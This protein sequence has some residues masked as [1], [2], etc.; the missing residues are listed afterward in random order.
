M[1]TVKQVAQLTGLS[2]HTVRFYDDNNLIQG[3]VRNAANQRLFT[4]E[5][6]EWLYM[7]KVMRRAGLTLKEIK[8]YGELYSAGDETIPQ[9]MEIIRRRYENAKKELEH[10]KIR[11]E[12]LETKLHHYEN[13]LQGKPDIWTY[14]FVINSM[15]KEKRSAE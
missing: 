13:L 12:A 1:Y 9:R 4:D 15:E 8:I 2:A 6:V 3:V 10:I 11:M 14:D 5:A 7:C